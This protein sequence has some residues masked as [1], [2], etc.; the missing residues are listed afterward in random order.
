MPEIV[1]NWHPALVHFPIALTIT[2]T[3][4]ML[5][6]SRRSADPLLVP[7]A[8]LLLRLAAGTA[9]VAAIFGWQAFQSVEHDAAGHLVMLSH[10]NWALSST[11]GLLLATIW[12]AFGHAAQRH[13]VLVLLTLSAGIVVTAWLGGEMVYRHGIGVSAA[14]FAPTAGPPVP[15]VPQATP[16]AAPLLPGEHI[17]QDGK[18][19][20]H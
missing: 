3:L 12:D 5:A 16:A 13:L 20:H 7:S 9:V 11:A 18:R 8:R 14:A 1:P 2:A 6:A 19:H 10:R 4:L 17:H 15:N